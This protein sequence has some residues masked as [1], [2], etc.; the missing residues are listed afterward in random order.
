V[1]LQSGSLDQ[2]Y[3]TMK[4]LSYL[5]ELDENPKSGWSNRPIGF[6]LTKADEC[7]ECFADPSGFAQARA[8]GLWR[9]CQER[10]RN[11]RF[12][13]VGVAGGCAYR[14]RREGKVRVPLRVEPR[15][16]IEPFEWLVK[17]G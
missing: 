11:Y 1:K 6:V 16:L 15:G 7:E 3:F 9:Q 13:A 17:Q 12:F 10:F 14:T 4:L 5:A 8:P 2:D